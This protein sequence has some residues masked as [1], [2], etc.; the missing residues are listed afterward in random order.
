MIK[1]LVIADDFTGAMDTGVQFNTKGALIRAVSKGQ[2]D[3]FQEADPDL[4]VLI[5]D[6]ETRHMEPAQAYQTVYQIVRAAVEAGV[7]CI[8]KKTDSGLRGNIGSELAALL[9]ASGGSRVHFAPAFPL[10]GR[11]TRQGVHYI[12]GCPVAD[13]VFGKDPFEPVRS[14]SV[15]DIIAFQSDVPAVSVGTQVP[16][17]LPDGVIIYD[18]ASDE[19]LSAIAAQLQARGELKLLAGCAGFASAL[20]DLLGMEGAG[21]RL[22][23]VPQKLLV[24]CGSTNPITLRQ[25]DEAQRSGALRI[26]LTP[27]QK[28]DEN[29]LASPEGLRFTAEWISQ[30]KDVSLAIIEGNQTGEGGATLRCAARLGMDLEQVRFQISQTMGGVLERLLSLGLEATVLVTGGDT[31][32]A[33]MQRIGQDKLIPLGELAPGVVLSQI[34]YCRKK[35]AILSKSGGFGSD[36]LLLDLKDKLS[37][38][39][40]EEEEVC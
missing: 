40:C 3:P 26:Q 11:V 28:L 15:A 27:E 29:W 39:E 37:L 17:D 25:L 4:Q 18:S 7:S 24:V 8:Y 19:H 36:R 5:I 2:I 33:F 16:L 38:Q 1:L 6:A 20:P 21:P 32:R 23:S 12:N 31:L 9:D 13:S 10:L 34:E 30:I 35:Y 22:P 14:S